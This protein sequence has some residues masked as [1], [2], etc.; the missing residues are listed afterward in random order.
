MTDKWVVYSWAGSSPSGK[1]Q[2]WAAFAAVDG[3]T[4][5]G[6][7]RWF[8]AWRQYCFYPEYSTVWNDECLH[9]VARYLA[10]VNRE[11]KESK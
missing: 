11:H 8:P 4:R 5:L 7:I 3:T 2:K 10:R 6:E 1:T 9:E